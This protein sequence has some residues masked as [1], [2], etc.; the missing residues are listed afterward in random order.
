MTG[1]ISEVACV[2]ESPLGSTRRQRKARIL[3]VPGFVA[4][5]YSEIERSFVELCANADPGL[6]FLWLVPD[7]SCRYLSFANADSRLTL[8]EPSYVPHLR[9]HG[10]P[11]VVGNISK[12]NILANLALAWRLFCRYRIDAVYTHFGFERFWAVFLAKLFGRRVVWNEHWHSLG[13]RYGWAKRAFYRIFVD[14]FVSVSHYITGTLPIGCRVHTIPNSIKPASGAA[15]LAS[16]ADLRRRFGL[17]VD[18]IVVLMVAAFTQQKRHRLAME[19]CDQIV[20]RHDDVVFIFLGEGATRPFFL[21]EATERRISDRIVAPGYVKNVEDYYALSDICMLTSRDEGFGYAVL[22]A[23]NYSRPVV[24]FDSGALPE[25]VVDGATGFVVP[26]H[27]VGEFTRKLSVLVGDASLRN[28]MGQRGRHVVERRYSRETWIRE[29][30]V[31][32]ATIVQAHR[33]CGTQRP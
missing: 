29:L 5:T 17:G 31:T 9:E 33:S 32:L 22:E 6:E 18:T 16:R 7:M 13:M 3:F 19:I 30:N 24:V 12:Y 26:D 15:R 8:K 20:H 1:R 21:N 14:E 10:I 11:Y 28:A 2:P 27:D 25:L 4:D 23:M